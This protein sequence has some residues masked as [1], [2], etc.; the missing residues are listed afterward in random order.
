MICFYHTMAEARPFFDRELRPNPVLGPGGVRA[1]FIIAIGVSLIVSAGFFAAGAWPIFGFFGLDVFGLY[2]AF[3]IVKRR[4]ERREWLRLDREALTLHRQAHA[5]GDWQEVVRLE[6]TWA[7]VE[8]RPI[9]TIGGP[10]GEVTVAHL[11]LWSHGHATEC[12][13]FL[14]VPEKQQIA[15]ELTDALRNRAAQPLFN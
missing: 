15:A 2:L 3:R 8:C 10:G 12:G 11:L 1:I 6:P 5:Q 13:T 9:P 14:P 7:R 4:A